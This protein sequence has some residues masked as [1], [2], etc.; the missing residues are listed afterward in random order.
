[1]ATQLGEAIFLASTH[2]IGMKTETT[3]GTAVSL[4]DADF[5]FLCFNI[6]LAP[7]IDENKR[8]YAYG[9]P[10]PL[11]SVMGAQMVTL[12]FDMHMQG[13][14][15][16]GQDPTL[17][18]PLAACGFQL[19]ANSL[20]RQA[21][22]GLPNTTL[23]MAIELQENVASSIRGKKYLMK[24]AGGTK[25]TWH[26]D[27]SGQMQI[28]S[29][30]F[31]AALVSITDLTAGTLNVPVLTSDTGVPSSV[32]GITCSYTPTGGSAFPLTT[33]TMTVDFGLKSKLVEY[34]QDG[35]G[36]AYTVVTDYDPIIDVNIL[37]PLEAQFGIYAQ[38]TSTVV[39][40]QFDA[41]LGTAQYK[42]LEIIANKV[43]IVK[44]E[45]LGER[46]GIDSENLQFLVTLPATGDAIGLYQRIT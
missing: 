23:T 37:I 25:L 21:V 42:E 39:L 8:K 28:A 6:K 16:T 35:T 17:F 46:D 15:V 20:F 7:K 10:L 27:G 4:A 45:E 11:Q 24:G 22:L 12:S 14:G 1:M 5:K 13:S 29:F 38:L 34:V 18:I 40:G 3:P 9:N 32:L 41:T 36:C 44:G 30:T 2:R 33:N 26:F 43:Q 19:S 31:D